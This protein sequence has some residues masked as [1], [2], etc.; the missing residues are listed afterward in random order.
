MPIRPATNRVLCP[1]IATILWPNR[2]R[3]T[4][5]FKQD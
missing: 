1:Q 5:I 4:I 2:D 3:V